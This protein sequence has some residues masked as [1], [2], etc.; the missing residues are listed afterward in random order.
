M[1]LQSVRMFLAVCSLAL[2]VLP[3][4]IASAQD[5]GQVASDAQ[6]LMT[7]VNGV[8]SAVVSADWGTARSG[9]NDFDDLW[10]VVED[11]FRAMSREDYRAIEDHQGT[12]RGLL[13]VDAPN[14]DQ[15]RGELSAERDLLVKFGATN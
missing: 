1:S 9:W 12:I 7:V 3:T 10:N 4:T 2:T 13:R 6:R 15:I 8:D 5:A 11:G 14:A